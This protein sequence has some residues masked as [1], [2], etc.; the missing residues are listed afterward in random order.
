[1]KGVR[2]FMRTFSIG[3]IDMSAEELKSGLWMLTRCVGAGLLS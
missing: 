3:D 1:M 2:Y